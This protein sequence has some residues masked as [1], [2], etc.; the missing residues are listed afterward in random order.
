MIEQ[1]CRHGKIRVSVCLAENEIEGFNSVRPSGSRP[2]DLVFSLSRRPTLRTL[3]QRIVRKNVKSTWCLLFVYAGFK[4]LRTLVIVALG[5][6]LRKR[7]KVKLMSP[8]L[9]I[10]RVPQMRYGCQ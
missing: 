4:C 7:E 10:Q 6:G 1:L 8:E 9:V 2:A 3:T 5:L